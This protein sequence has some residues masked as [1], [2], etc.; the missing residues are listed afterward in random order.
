VIGEAAAHVSERLRSEPP[1][2]PWTDVVGFRNILV[3]GY[4]GLDWEL[5]WRAATSSVP[6]LR[7]R[8]AAI[9]ADLGQ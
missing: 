3:H 8:V 5:V 6:A 4:F 9:L 2:A 1:E 7:E